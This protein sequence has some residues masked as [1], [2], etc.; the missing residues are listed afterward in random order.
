VLLKATAKEKDLKNRL[1]R[2]TNPS[3]LIFF[4]PQNPVPPSETMKN[5]LRFSEDI[6]I[7]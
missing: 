1:A 6:A 5:L 7:L 4:T 2:K 3:V